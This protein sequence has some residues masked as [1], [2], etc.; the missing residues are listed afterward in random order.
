MM[1]KFHH[2]G[3]SM[4]RWKTYYIFLHEDNYFTMFM[5]MNW[6][7]NLEPDGIYTFFRYTD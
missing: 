3:L 1:Q 4:I 2:K 5:N 6:T 7:I